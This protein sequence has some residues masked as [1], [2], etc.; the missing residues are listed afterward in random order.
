[1]KRVFI[2]LFF[3]FWA[4]SAWSQELNCNVDIITKQVQST[5][6]EIFNDLKN[7]ILQFMNNRKWTS[8]N[9]QMAERI[10]CNF[11]V[12]V[13]E[14]NIDQ[15]RTRLTI[16]SSRPVYGTNY[17]TVVFKHIDE[18]FDFQYSQLQAMDFQENVF[19][20]NLTS[21]F[22]FYAY[23]IIGMDYD[24]YHLYGGTDYYNKAMSVKNSANNAIGWGPQDGKGNKNRYYLIE[25]LLDERF[26]PMRTALYQYHMKGLDIMTKDLDGGRDAVYESLLNMKKVFEVLPNSVSLKVFFNAKNAELI[27]LYS[28][29]SPGMK[30][31]V[32]ELLS[33]ID[34]SNRNDY[35]SGI[36]KT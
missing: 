9:Y 1:M 2:G 24:T 17:N 29:A 20:S 18:S 15:F 8:D 23:L 19:T 34:P 21:V 36:L 28:K 25:N 32:V 5:N 16:Q 3:I 31:K 26:K 10:D 6:R 30:N 27:S 14:F 11:I 4:V 22:A 35:E 12:E 33:K 7:S 13:E